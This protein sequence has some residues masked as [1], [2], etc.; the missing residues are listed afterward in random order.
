VKLPAEPD[1]EI[2]AELGYGG[3]TVN[4]CEDE[5]LLGYA[6]GPVSPLKTAT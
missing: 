2:V 1:D 6:V 3:L 4:V 5:V